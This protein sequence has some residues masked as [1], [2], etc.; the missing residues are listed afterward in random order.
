[1]DGSAPGES[2]RIS[3]LYGRGVCNFYLT[4]G[5][6]VE[7]V[8]GWRDGEVS[9]GGVADV[10]LVLGCLPARIS[11]PPSRSLLQH[12]SPPVDVN[13]LFHIGVI[14]VAIGYVFNYLI[15]KADIEFADIGGMTGKGTILVF[16]HGLTFQGFG[17][18]LLMALRRPTAG[19][20]AASIAGVILP[21]E[22]AL[23]GRREPA[24]M[25]GLTVMLAL[26]YGR[27]VKPPRWLILAS[28]VAAMLAIPAT[29]TYRALQAE[30]DWTSIRQMELVANFREFVTKESILELRNAAAV[31]EATKATGHYEWGAG[32]WNHLVFRYIPGQIVG[33]R[34]K[35][36]LKFKTQWDLV[37]FGTTELGFQL[38]RGSTITGMGD[39]FQQFGFFGCLFFALVAVFFRSLWVTSSRPNAFFAQLLYIT[40]CTSA[41]RAVTH[42][43]L[44][45]LPGLLYNVIFLGLA[46]LYAKSPATRT[47]RPTHSSRRGRREGRSRAGMKKPDAVDHSVR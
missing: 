31:I 17:I 4:A 45:F 25:L 35:E 22:T 29:G 47:T 40:T 9:A 19:R 21:I 15:G 27:G 3:I 30:K 26:Y 23:A 12:A 5:N 39:A 16:F 32:Y 43:T 33:A 11:S 36:S 8:S 6:F 34:L 28:I 41:M 24:V 38:S 13:R 44:D 18:C 46:M 2:I 7:V 1:M 37:E 42:W 14:Y 20:V 10:Q